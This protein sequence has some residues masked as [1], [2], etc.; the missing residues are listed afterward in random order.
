MKQGKEGSLPSVHEMS[1][2]TFLDTFCYQDDGAPQRWLFARPFLRICSW[3]ENAGAGSVMVGGSFV[4]AKGDPGDMDI[5]VIFHRT[6]DIQHCPESLFVQ[7]AKLD[8][9]F[10]AEDQTELLASFVYLLATSKAG[11]S[12]DVVQIKLDPKVSDITVPAAAPVLYEQVRDMYEHRVQIHVHRNKGLIIPI[13]GVNTHAPWLQYFS[14][15]ACSSGW[16]VAPFVYGKVAV[17]ALAMSSRRNALVQDFRT[18]L[19]EVRKEHD[20]PISILAHSLGSY[21][22]ARYLTDMGSIS[23]RFSGVVFAGSI[24]RTDFDWRSHLEKLHVGAV[25]NTKSPGDSWVR[26]LPDGGRFLLRD[27]LY[28]RAATIGFTQEHDRLFEAEIPLLDHTNMF[29]R[30]VIKNWI[31]FFEL[32]LKHYERADSTLFS[33]EAF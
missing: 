20:G 23:E 30:D 33:P 8:I 14:L 26:H 18:W 2:E 21:I 5:L 4:S 17:T 13:H 7:E 10:L 15:L 9:Q 27:S 22:F 11:T 19:N 16:G 6:S 28:G 31:A 12:R 24:V 3:A 1:K 29:Q 25:M 32:A